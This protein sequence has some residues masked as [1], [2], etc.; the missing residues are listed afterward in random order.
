MTDRRWTGEMEEIPATFE[1]VGVTRHFHLGAAEM[2]RVLGLT[3]MADET[4]E[5]LDRSRT[6]EQTVVTLTEEIGKAT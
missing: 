4:P 5:T 2:C 6:R 3:S 1:Q